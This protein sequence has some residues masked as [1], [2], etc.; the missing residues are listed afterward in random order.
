MNIVVRGGEGQIT[1]K[2][3]RF[4]GQLFP[5]R[6]EADALS[7]LDGVRKKYWDARHHVYAYVTDSGRI[8]HFSDDGEP[9]GTGGRPVLE[10]LTR[11]ELTGSLLVVT[12]Y[13]GG[14]LLGTG[15]LTRAY[16]AAAEA[17][18]ASAVTAELIAGKSYRLQLTY[19]QA[20]KLEWLARESGGILLDTTYQETVTARM[21]IPDETETDFLSR[22]ADIFAGKVIAE[23]E[24]EKAYYRDE[25]GNVHYI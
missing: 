9:A 4:I 1:A 18:L 10:V 3:S 20:G 14:T 6:S 2:K 23:D 17:A 7:V 15:G 25:K 11:A 24:G 8:R 21:L 13:F 22:T 12:R 5:V 19:Q 16:G